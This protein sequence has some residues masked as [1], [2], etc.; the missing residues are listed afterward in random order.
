MTK[1]RTS[2]Q[3]FAEAGFLN[4]FMYLEF[5]ISLGECHRMIKKCERRIERYAEIVD[6]SSKWKYRFSS[7][8]RDY[9]DG[10]HDLLETYSDNITLLEENIDLIKSK[11]K[12]EYEIPYYDEVAEE[13]R[14]LPNLNT[15]MN[16]RRS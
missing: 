16:N 11:L 12:T 15:L 9:I 2:K 13:I 10:A 3:I 6:N 8:Y 1:K 14:R 5:S 7:R 4:I